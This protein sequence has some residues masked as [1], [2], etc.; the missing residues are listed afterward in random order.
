MVRGEAFISVRLWLSPDAYAH[1]L[2]LALP[3]QMLV[4]PPARRG[5]LRKLWQWRSR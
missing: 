1:G 4:P 5:R 3:K 2:A